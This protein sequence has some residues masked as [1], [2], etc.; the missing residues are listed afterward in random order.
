[1]AGKHS[2]NSFPSKFYIPPWVGKDFKF[3][4]FQGGHSAAKAV[5][6]VQMV[7]F[8]RKA[9]KAVKLYIFNLL[10]AKAAF[11]SSPNIHFFQHGNNPHCQ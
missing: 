7:D 1:M 9:V 6:A 3:M 10:A 5:K 8:E 4:V 2:I 11:L